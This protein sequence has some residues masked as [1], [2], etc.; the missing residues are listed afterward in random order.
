MSTRQRGQYSWSEEWKSLV[1]NFNFV[2]I[3]QNEEFTISDGT[4]RT[5]PLL[6][7]NGGSSLKLNGTL[8][9]EQ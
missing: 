3:N 5:T 9:L 7:M 1:T 4:T 2:V 6:Q 8:G